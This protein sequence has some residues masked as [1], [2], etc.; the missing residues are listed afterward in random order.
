MFFTLAAIPTPAAPNN[1]IG[2]ANTKMPA[3]A[4][5]PISAPTVARPVIIPGPDN[6]VIPAKKRAVKL[7]AGT[8]ANAII[9]GR[10]GGDAVEETVAEE[11]TEETAE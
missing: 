5:P 11:A 10:Q 1:V 6:P 7:I 4:P 3:V 8:I 2:A 9:E